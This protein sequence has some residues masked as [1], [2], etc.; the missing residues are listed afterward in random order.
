MVEA[1][2]ATVN[3][4]EWPD[5]RVEIDFHLPDG[6]WITVSLEQWRALEK[7]VREA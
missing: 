5:G 2:V 3:V 7:L 1:G 4:R 6:P